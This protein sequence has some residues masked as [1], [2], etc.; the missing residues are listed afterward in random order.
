MATILYWTDPDSG[1]TESVEFD[2]VPTQLHEDILEITS[3]PVEQGAE[4]VD[5]AREQPSRLTLEGFVSTVPNRRID[6]DAADAQVEL[7]VSEFTDPGTQSIKLEIASPK[8][9][10][11]S[12][13]ISLGI[14]ALGNALSGGPR[15]TFR[16]VARRARRQAFGSFYKQSSERNR[17]RDVY[18]KLQGAQ[19][20]RALITA[21]TPLREHFDMLLERLPAQQNEEDGTGATFEIDLRRIRVA[22]TETVQS[23]EPAE[24]RGAVAKSGGSKNPKPDPNADAKNEVANRSLIAMGQDAGLLPSF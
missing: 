21:Q 4:M 8:P 20:K 9:R 6:V 3:H 14:T 10:S 5:H 12:G 18:E 7:E 16:G 15:G 2:V 24:K 17:P 13:L 23:P 11:L 1:L 19:I 22:D